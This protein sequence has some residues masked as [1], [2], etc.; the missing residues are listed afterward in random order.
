[1]FLVLSLDTRKPQVQVAN[2]PSQAVRIQPE[3]PSKQVP[4]KGFGDWVAALDPSYRGLA[5]L[6]FRVSL[7]FQ[8]PMTCESFSER[9]RTVTTGFMARFW[10]GSKVLACGVGG[11]GVGAGFQVVHAPQKKTLMTYKL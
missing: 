3:I 11:R 6:G 9:Y 5:G 10:L 7:R 1:M 2:N 4:N 8:G